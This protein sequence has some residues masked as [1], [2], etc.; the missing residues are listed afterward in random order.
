MLLQLGCILLAA[1]ILLCAVLPGY[2]HTDKELVPAEA[3]T[4]QVKDTG[5]ESGFSDNA[6]LSS[7]FIC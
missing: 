5:S 4:V 3:N 1:V 7:I 6:D 2:V